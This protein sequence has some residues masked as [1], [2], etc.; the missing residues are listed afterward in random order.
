MSKKF[1]NNLPSNAYDTQ[2]N[3]GWLTLGQNLGRR[4]LTNVSQILAQSGRDMNELD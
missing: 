2:I 3:R 1:G 4:V